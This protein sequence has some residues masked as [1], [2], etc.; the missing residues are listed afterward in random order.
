MSN[1]PSKALFHERGLRI[2]SLLF[3]VYGAWQQAGEGLNS[4]RAVHQSDIPF[5]SWSKKILINYQSQ[6]EKERGQK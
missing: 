5:L 4:L 2:K 1:L 3:F 6:H